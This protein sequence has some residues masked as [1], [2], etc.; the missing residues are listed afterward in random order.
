ML[1]RLGELRY[2]RPF[3]LH[4]DWGYF[5]NLLDSD[6]ASARCS[7]VSNHLGPVHHQRFKKFRSHCFSQEWLGKCASAELPTFPQGFGEGSG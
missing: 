1:H 7:P 2:A 5:L 6:Q 4:N 3:Q